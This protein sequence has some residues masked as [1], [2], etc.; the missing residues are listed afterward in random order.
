[1]YLLGIIEIAIGLLV[2]L[3]PKLGGYIVMAFLI[4]ISINLITMQSHHHANYAQIMT[5]YDVALHDIAL[6][7]CAYAFVLLSKEVGK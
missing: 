7:I 4:V 2:F 3:K 1:M 5:H 6:S